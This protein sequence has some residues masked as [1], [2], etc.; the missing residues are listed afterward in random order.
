MKFENILKNLVKSKRIKQTILEEVEEEYGSLD[1]QLNTI[2]DELNYYVDNN[3]LPA[4]DTK[5]LI[6]QL[7]EE[8]EEI[9]ED[10]IVPISS[11]RKRTLS[12][13]SE[14]IN[15]LCK[16]YSIARIHEEYSYS[17]EIFKKIKAFVDEIDPD[18][19]SS[20]VYMTDEI[21]RLGKTVPLWI[22]D[23]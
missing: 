9:E 17:D 12:E 4:G 14:S 1:L 6:A 7:T 11:S 10:E 3:V 15:S 5:R 8:E 13:I 16:V 22:L 18:T 21:I 19:V 2:I 23:V 20:I